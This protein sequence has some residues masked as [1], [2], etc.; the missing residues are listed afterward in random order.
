MLEKI[1]ESLDQKV[2]TPELKESLEAQ[3]N[4]AVE[5][6]SSVIADDIIEEKIDFLNEKS[7]EHIQMLDEKSEEYIQMLDEKS[8]EYIRMLDEK[9]EE[10]AD[11]KQVD[12]LESVDNYLDRIIDEFAD[13]ADDALNQSL[14]SEKASMIIEAFDSML[15]ATG[16]E[17]AKIVEAK[18]DGTAENQLE[19]SIEK[20][21][22]L[23]EKNI[24]L[25]DQN[26]TINEENNTL[27]KMGVITEMKEDLSIVKA[28]KFERMASM[29][30]F[31]KDE[32]FVNKL[33]RI[34]D[35]V[36]GSVE[37][38]K[39]IKQR[40]DEKVEKPVWAHLI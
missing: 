1:F 37:S 9:V 22:S 17:V 39:K 3:I 18:D 4:E 11:T 23:I 2:F 24:A 38:S 32:T 34:K 29:V 12:M 15:V 27:I 40:I 7:E 14:K 19:K 28:E 21:D 35:M 33:E 6:K 10:Y 26:D 25:N 5:L 36:E 8:E 20:Y 31:T 13:Y 16:V 30:E